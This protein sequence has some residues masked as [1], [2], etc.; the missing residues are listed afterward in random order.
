MDEKFLCFAWWPVHLLLPE[1][2]LVMFDVTGTSGL[3][4]LLRVL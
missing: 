1:V 4:R 3:R 2:F